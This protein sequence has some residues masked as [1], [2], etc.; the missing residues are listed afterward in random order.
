L[1]RKL[2]QAGYRVVCIDNLR[3]GGRSL[4]D[5][6]DHPHFLFRKLDV[7]NFSDVAR[8]IASDPYFAVVHLAAIVGDGL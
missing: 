8:M 7:T 5:I 6:W 4:M 2:L 1:V 3:Y